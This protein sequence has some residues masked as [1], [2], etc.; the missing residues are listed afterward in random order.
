MRK[1]LLHDSVEVYR[2]DIPNYLTDENT[3]ALEF[4]N[5]YQRFGFAYSGGWA[6]Q[7]ARHIDIISALEV[8]GDK[9][10]KWRRKRLRSR[11]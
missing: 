7:P 8:E 11:S 10:E 3:E 2:I 6:Q 9:L 4:F 1:M 5:N